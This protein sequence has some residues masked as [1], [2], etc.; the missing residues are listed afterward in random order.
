MW[1][2]WVLILS[3]AL[4]T[5][6]S[7]LLG[8]EALIGR[9]VNSRVEMYFHFVPAGVISALV[10]SQLFVTNKGQLSLSIPVLVGGCVVA[11]CMKITKSFLLAIILGVVVGALVNQLIHLHTIPL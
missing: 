7:R 10:V 11:V 9:Q 4:V 2:N 6:V 8:I 5:Y 3:L 1:N